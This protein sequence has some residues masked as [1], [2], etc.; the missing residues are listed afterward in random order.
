M[1]ILVIDDDKLLTEPLLWRLNQE[2]HKVTHC[3]SISDVLDEAGRAKVS[4]PDC[5]ILDILMPRGDRYSKIETRAGRDTGLKLLGDMRKQW[6]LVPVIIVSVRRD[7]NLDDIR[8]KYG[9][10]VKEVL[11]KP[12][13]PTEV[14]NEIKKL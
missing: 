6:P 7:L 5:I 3:Q 13:T 4:E 11:L 9:N 14:I 12:V 10:N 1:R 8:D 2:G